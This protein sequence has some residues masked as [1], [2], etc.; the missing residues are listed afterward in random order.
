MT[1]NTK[2]QLRQQLKDWCKAH[3]P[4]TNAVHAAAVAQRVLGLIKETASVKVVACYLPMTDEVDSLPLLNQLRM[5]GYT[6]ALPVVAAKD[7]KLVFRLYDPK[8]ALS[9]DKIGLPA[10]DLG[11]PLLTPDLMIVPLLGFNAD[12]YRLGRGGGYYDRTLEGLSGIVT[13]GLGYNA[14]QIVFSP[15]SHDVALDYIVTE[16]HVLTRQRP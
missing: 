6:V 15:D 4:G 9:R 13:I 2:P 12:N 11:A 7:E 3:L 14:Q 5:A 1:D 16:S 10:P 8:N